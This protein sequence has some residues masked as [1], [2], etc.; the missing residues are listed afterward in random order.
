[1]S[2][3]RIDVAIV[4]AGPAGVTTSLF[5]SK[6]GIP[7]ILFEKETF[8]RD[9]VCGDALSG[10]SVSIL[11]RLNP[12]LIDMME[13]SDDFIGSWGVRFVAPNGKALDIPFKKNPEKQVHAPGFLAPRLIFDNVLVEE[14][15]SGTVDFRQST[16]VTAVERTTEGVRLQYS[17]NGTAGEVRA[18]MVIGAGGDRSLIRDKLT[19]YKMDRRYYCAGLRAYYENVGGMHEQNF[20]E[21]HFL[22][23]ILPG[24]LWIFPLPGNRVNVG[25]G[26][27][28]GSMKNKQ[29]SLKKVMQNALKEN[30]LIRDRFKDARLVDDIKGWGLP[31]GS[32]KRKLSGDRFLLT[33]DAA[34]LIDPFTGEGIGNAMYSGM[35]AARWVEKALGSD[36]VSASFLSGYDQE[37]Y[38]GLWDELKLSATLQKLVHFPWLFNFVVNRALANKTISEMMSCMFDDLDMRARLRSPS[39]YLRM[40]FNY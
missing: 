24:Y 37:V 10:K 34:S 22:K 11:K 1:M 23:E 16:P 39:F 6:A 40:L 13:Q 5:L 2:A 35:L 7:H 19:G 32:V 21:L 14:L 31:L 30:H 36:T 9:K 38:A 15:D 25:I 27:L 8:P 28:S 12:S 17:Q 18:K 3:D 26:M 20:I 33:G 29:I 4:G